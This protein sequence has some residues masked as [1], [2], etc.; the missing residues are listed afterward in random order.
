[1]YYLKIT[2]FQT[3]FVQNKSTFFNKNHQYRPLENQ[4]FDFFLFICTY[5]F[6][7]NL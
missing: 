5:L 6:H 4:T 2:F 3:L 7:F 1:M